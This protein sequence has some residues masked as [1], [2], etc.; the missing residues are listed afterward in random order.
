M[1]FLGIAGYV[2]A[3]GD[4]FLIDARAL[5]NIGVMAFLTTIVSLIKAFL[6]NRSGEFVGAVKVIN[7]DQK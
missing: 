3:L 6:T 7:E 4:I 1:A 5:I 2:I